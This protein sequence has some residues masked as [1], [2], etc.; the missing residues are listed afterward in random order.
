MG[1]SPEIL[2]VLNSTIYPGHPLAAKWPVDGPLFYR[3]PVKDHLAASGRV[4]CLWFA[5]EFDTYNISG[6]DP[7]SLISLLHEMS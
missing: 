6:D 4:G 5:L 2:Y 7:M 3:E 1:S